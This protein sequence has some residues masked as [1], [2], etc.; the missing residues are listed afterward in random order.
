MIT[1]RKEGIKYLKSEQLYISGE[2]VKALFLLI[3]AKNTQN[4]FMLQDSVEHV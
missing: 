1:L 3:E 4:H 2:K